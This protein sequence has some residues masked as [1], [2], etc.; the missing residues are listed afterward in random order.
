M[1]DETLLKKI[2]YPVT[3]VWL[4]IL[5][6]TTYLY[7]RQRKSPVI[8]YRSVTLSLLMVIGNALVT[9]LYLGREPTINQFPCFLSL[10]IS[11]VGIPLW[12]T[13]MAGRFAR[14]AF[15][16]RVS[17]AKLAVEHQEHEP[18]CVN[19][20]NSE[21]DDNSLPTLNENWYFKH[22]NKFTT[23]YMLK[24]IG[25]AVAL[26]VV[27]T[28]LVQIFTT[29][30]R[31]SPMA[32]GNC[33]IGWEFIPIYSTSAIYVLVICPIF[34]SWIRGV[35]D[36]YGIKRE[37]IA[38]LT[39]GITAF[40]L[41]AIFLM[42]PSLEDV[43]LKFPAAHWSVVAF[44]L[45]HLI[46]IVLPTIDAMRGT[47]QPKVR[48]NMATFESILEDPQQFEVFK[49]FSL[50]DFTVENALF[51]EQ[52]MRFRVLCNDQEGGKESMSNQVLLEISSI[53]NQFML[54]GAELQL[55]VD[56]EILNE[57]QY[58]FQA[59]DISPDIFDKA[60]AQVR[61]I[62]FHHTYPRFVREGQTRLRETG[63]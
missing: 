62:M 58:R 36:V 23:K 19:I 11:S 59:Q 35:E 39:L 13:S 8:R 31:I 3:V 41:Y 7:I 6:S 61:N 22:R 53:Y 9:T 14:L 37:L 5:L 20:E 15:L 38:D 12:I 52:M 63:I 51:Y 60:L 44:V 2:Y 40:I 25:G 10:W 26:Q 16:Y 50:R 28:I 48:S 56:E 18:H 21:K 49:R 54:Q 17:Q 29:K 46:S 45:S 4:L 32:A 30:F 24:W 42:L 57:I 27:L 34:L 43:L 33:L 55:H 1:I 47:R